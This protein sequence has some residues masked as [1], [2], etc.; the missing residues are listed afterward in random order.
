[1][2]CSVWAA[3]AVLIHV[4]SAFA[5][6]GAST[7]SW[8]SYGGAPGG[9]HHSAATQINALNVANLEVAWVHRSGDVRQA[10]NMLSMDKLEGALAKSAFMVTPIVVND[11]LY[12]CTPFDRVFGIC[13]RIGE[14]PVLGARAKAK[15]H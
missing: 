1:M 6:D 2:R 8:P 3:L 4:G 7:L 13:T 12:Y 10:V 11:T 15:R 9:G 5:D 14:A